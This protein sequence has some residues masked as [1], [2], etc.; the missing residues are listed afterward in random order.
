MKLSN[1]DPKDRILGA[2][3][4]GLRQ[5]PPDAQLRLVRQL[6]LNSLELGIANAPMDLPQDASEEALKN[7]A[8][9]YEKYGVPLFCAATGNDF[10]VC[11]EEL[12]AQAQKVRAVIRLCGRLHIR[13]LRIFCGFKKREEMSGDCVEMLLK[14][15]MDVQKTAEMCNVTLAVETHGAVEPCGSGVLHFRSITTQAEDLLM[16]LER[17]G[18]KIKI[19]FDPANLTAVGEKNLLSFWNAIRRDTA[20]IHLKDFKADASGA[21]HPT[22]FGCGDTDWSELAAVLRDSGLPVFFEYE[23]CQDVD[24]GLE[25]C[26]KNWCES[27]RME[28]HEHFELS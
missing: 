1:C 17:T 18:H 3:A 15:L 22:A 12:E 16:L 7:V 11:G 14:T 10:T 5:L 13:V 25:K 23:N 2:A 20:Y 9:A 26:W 6:G 4:W 28:A 24:S 19:V 21:L 27:E 8:D